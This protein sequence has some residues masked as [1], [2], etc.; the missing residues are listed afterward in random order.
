MHVHLVEFIRRKRKRE[1]SHFNIIMIDAYR[2]LLLMF[3]LQNCKKYHANLERVSPIKLLQE[4]Q[5]FP[6]SVAI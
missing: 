3:R 1:G 2:K 5:L 4:K 6:I